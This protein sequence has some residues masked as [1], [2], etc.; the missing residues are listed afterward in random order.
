[1]IVVRYKVIKSLYDRRISGDLIETF[2]I[3]NGFERIP[4]HP[5]FQLHSSSHCTRG[6]SM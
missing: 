6:H 5:F 4:S 3:L 2:E 1:V